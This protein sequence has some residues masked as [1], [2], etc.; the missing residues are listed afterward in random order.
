[1]DHDM[2]MSNDCMPCRDNNERRAASSGPFASLDAITR[3]YGSSNGCGFGKLFL[4]L[5]IGMVLGYIL[6]MTNAL[7]KI[8]G[9]GGDAGEPTA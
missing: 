1:M 2:R 5:I 7:G 6:H 9:K 4:W 8:F 3:L